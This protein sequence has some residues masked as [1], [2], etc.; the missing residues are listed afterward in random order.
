MASIDTVQGEWCRKYVVVLS[1]RKLWCGCVFD[2]VFVGGIAAGCHA[3]FH[4][5]SGYARISKKRIASFFVLEG[6]DLY[7]IIGRNDCA[8]LSRLSVEMIRAVAD[9]CVS[10]I[11]PLLVDRNCLSPPKQALSRD[12]Q[13][14]FSQYS[15]VMEGGKDRDSV[16]I[17][18]SR[19]YPFPNPPQSAV[20]A[21]PFSIHQSPTAERL[22]RCF[23]LLKKPALLAMNSLFKQCPSLHPLIIARF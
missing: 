12:T 6:R 22:S 8:V 10:S 20:C 5:C 16:S 13:H 18:Q 4:G 14:A 7:T 17:G 19:L 23:S 21:K 1:Q 15:H 11:Q 9:R 3:S 2:C